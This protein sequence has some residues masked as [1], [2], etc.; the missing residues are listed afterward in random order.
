MALI[1]LSELLSDAECHTIR[2]TVLA[3][4]PEWEL[5]H[6]LAPFYTLGVPSYLDARARDGRYYQKAAAKNGLMIDHFDWLYERLSGC[7]E[8]KLGAPVLYDDHFARPGFHV[9]SDSALFEIQAGSIHFDLQYLLLDWTHA[10]EPQMSTPVSFTLAAALPSGGGGLKLWDITYEEQLNLSKEERAALM[11]QRSCEFLPYQVGKMVVHS[12]H[13]LH[14]IAEFSDVQPG[15]Q[16]IT[17]QGHGIQCADG[18]H[19]YW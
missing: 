14:Q 11:E 17:L 9:Y 13:Q 15:D 3:L 6:L 2:D 19:L 7:L 5:R 8:E 18:W 4:K 1:P 12:G 16:R 10:P